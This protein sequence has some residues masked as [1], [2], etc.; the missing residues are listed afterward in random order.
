MSAWLP[1]LI[2]CLVLELTPGPNMGY[3]AV[4]SMSQ[5][6]RAG[7]AAIVGIALGLLVIGLLASLGM[8]HLISSTSWVGQV[9]SWCGF[10]Y[11]LW[12]AWDSWR[13]SNEVSP[14]AANLQVRYGA[15]FRRGLI[16][17]LLNPKAFLFY[18]VTLPALVAQPS[19]RGVLIA[20]LVVI[21][22]SIATLV[23]V[24][25]VMLASHYQS[26]LAASRHGQHI[27]RVMALLLVAIAVWF[28]ASNHLFSWLA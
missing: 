13:T 6:K 9:I 2:T 3:L 17:N 18:A 12:L 25:V 23:H 8:A 4:L 27:R 28:A 11:L 10:G 21:S 19:A 20:T 26:W 7:L 15:Y 24:I 22:V 14:A 5:G 1:F 16:T